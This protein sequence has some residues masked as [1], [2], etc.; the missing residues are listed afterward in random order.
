MIWFVG[1]ISEWK[2]MGYS[3]RYL[4]PTN[5]IKFI[6]W[7]Q[8]IPFFPE[9][10]EI[11]GKGRKELRIDE[12]NYIQELTKINEWLNWESANAAKEIHSIII[13]D[14]RAASGKKNNEWNVLNEL[15]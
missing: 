9:V 10:N 15:F 14:R 1:S 3:F 12:A 4:S 6:Y 2:E 7:A 11:D 13:W 8:S 5:Q